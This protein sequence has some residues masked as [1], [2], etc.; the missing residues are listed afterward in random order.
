MDSEFQRRRNFVD[1]M[2]GKE[3]Y[4]SCTMSTVPKKLE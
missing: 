3:L 1:D 2:E 4:M